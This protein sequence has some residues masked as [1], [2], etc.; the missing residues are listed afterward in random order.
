[1]NYFFLLIIIILSIVLFAKNTVRQTKIDTFSDYKLLETNN[2]LA[3]GN[4]EFNNWG[5]SRNWNSDNK[6][7]KCGINSCTTGDFNVPIPFNGMGSLF[8]SGF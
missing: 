7:G 4:W 2:E 8:S 5:S 6:C 3:T 1:M